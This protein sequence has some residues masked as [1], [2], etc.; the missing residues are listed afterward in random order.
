MVQA[1]LKNIVLIT[2]SN[3]ADP[4]NVCS[5]HLG[6]LALEAYLAAHG[7]FAV[8]I[9][10]NLSLL[11]G[12]DPH[13]V[14]ISSVTENYGLAISM[15]KAIKKS[16]PIPVVVGG[17]HITSCPKSLDPVFDA[18]IAGEGEETFLEFL[19]A[20][21]R[22]DDVPGI[23]SWRDGAVR[24]SPRRKNLADLDALPHV[25]RTRWVERLG[26][27][28]VMTSRGCP[29]GCAFC[30][31]PLMWGGCR[32]FSPSYV[33][34]EIKE[35]VEHF[36]AK[37][38]RFFDDVLTLDRKRLSLIVEMI[39]AECLHQVVT[40]S[41]FS[42]SNLL[43][44]EKLQLLA[45]GNIKF[46]AFGLES[47]SAAVLDTLKDRPGTVE[48]SQKAIDMGFEEG[49]YMGCSVIIG[50]PHETEDD[51]LTTFAFL[52]KNEAKLFEVEINPLVPHPGTPIWDYAIARGLVSTSM[53]WSLLK[54][55]SYIPLFNPERYIYLNEMM[56][57]EK[58]L[59][60][61]KGFKSLHSKMIKMDIIK[62]HFGDMDVVAR[63]RPPDNREQ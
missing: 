6:P 27:P 21:P 17:V 55:Y 30:S 32:T 42:R 57:Y 43:D 2:A 52:S 60:Y 12:L 53:D 54:D 5:A 45:R 10:D 20:Y 8:S 18:G 16:F 25:R 51:L 15:A 48:E 34:T 28:L 19:T 49:I 62:K 61:L 44:R 36:G 13:L 7:D 59:Y 38:I 56:P 33:L 11:D 26:L 14:G 24:V 22:F 4:Y 35:L 3:P 31:S 40:F 47:A 9:I 23:L 63:L 37:Y 41:C 39:R 50:A 29:Y 1:P 58:F 46:V